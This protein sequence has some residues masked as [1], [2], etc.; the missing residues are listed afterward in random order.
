MS[1]RHFI[2]AMGKEI[3]ESKNCFYPK[4]MILQVAELSPSAWYD[5]PNGIKKT[6]KRIKK[7]K[8]KIKFYPD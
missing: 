3:S 6:I 7:E 4:R 1:A 2:E 8:K 5:K